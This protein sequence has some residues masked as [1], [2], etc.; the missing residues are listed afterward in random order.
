ME[1]P[2]VVGGM[3]HWSCDIVPLTRPK[4][5]KSSRPAHKSSEWIPWPSLEGAK[6]RQRGS[7]LRKFCPFFCMNSMDWLLSTWFCWRHL[8]IQA[9]AKPSIWYP[10]SCSIPLPLRRSLMRIW[11]PWEMNEAF[12]NNNLEYSLYTEFDMFLCLHFLSITWGKILMLHFKGLG[13]L[14]SGDPWYIILK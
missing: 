6:G 5:C 8:D 12:K 10:V 4:G 13:S 2:M 11:D 14:P 9:K 7:N 1:T 3:S